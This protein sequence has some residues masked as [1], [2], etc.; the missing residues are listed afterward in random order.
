MSNLIVSNIDT[1]SVNGSS[2][3]ILTT[4]GDKTVRIPVISVRASATQVLSVDQ[5]V[6]M[7]Y[8]EV[9]VDTES[10][11]NASLNRYTPTIPGYYY[12]TQAFYATVT[13]NSLGAISS[14]YKNG[15]EALW[16][17][18]GSTSASRATALVSGTIYMNGTTD[19]VEGFAYVFMGGAGTIT[20]AASGSRNYM[21]GFLVRSE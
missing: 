17:E 4:T 3:E 1:N 13:A 20:K 19:Y 10:A 16:V 6:K 21:S 7:V 18:A 2:G 5:Y 12:F 9:T 11:W 8:G 14:I 15:T